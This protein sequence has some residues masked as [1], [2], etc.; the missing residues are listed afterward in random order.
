LPFDEHHHGNKFKRRY[1][2]H[3]E[4]L[5]SLRR[6]FL[7]QTEEKRNFFGFKQ[8]LTVRQNVIDDLLLHEHDVNASEKERQEGMKKH[9]KQK[10]KKIII[11]INEKKNIFL[12]R[13]S[14]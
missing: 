6:L 8:R 9:H 2:K 13:R 4:F 10:K 3:E 14:N 12:G 1:E 7:Q 5:I 11:K